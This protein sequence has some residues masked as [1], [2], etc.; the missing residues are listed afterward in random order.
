MKPNL[1]ELVHIMN[2][3]LSAGLINSSRALV[4]NTLSTIAADRMSPGSMSTLDVS[5]IRVLCNA[6]YQVMTSS[7]SSTSG[8]SNSATKAGFLGN[9][10]KSDAKKTD[11]T[12]TAATTS[13]AAI[14]SSIKHVVTGKH[15]IVSLGNR[16]VLWCGP[17]KQLAPSTG[18]NSA[19]QDANCVVNEA[20]QS[21]TLL[22]PALNIKAEDIVHTNG[23]GDAF[24]AGLL[25]EIVQKYHA[26]KEGDVQVTGAK[27]LLLPDKECIQKGLLSAHHWLVTK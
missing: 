17:V 8:S 21:A 25:A 24:C 12:A 6:L 9:F 5:D 2:H 11:S 19:S 4:Q 7:S 22:I 14:G 10:M 26:S 20:T 13:T 23:A 15:I 18:N 3:C 1:T 16:G 27:T